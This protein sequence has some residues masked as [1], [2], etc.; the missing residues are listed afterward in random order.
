ML[1]RDS[2]L[3]IL[4]FVLAFA[5]RILSLDAFMMA[6]EQLWIRRSVDFLK[7]VLSFDFRDTLIS[8]HPG[9]VTMWLGSVPIAFAKKILHYGHLKDLLW[10]AKI[11]FAIATAATITAACALLLRTYGRRAALIAGLL[12]ATDPFFTA[13]SRIIHLDAVL[14]CTMTLSILFVIYFLRKAEEIKYLITS[15]VFGG[16]ALLAKVPGVFLIVFIPAVFFLDL[17]CRGRGEGGFAGCL[18]KRVK[19]YGI[20]LAT[21]AI[22]VFIFWPAMWVDPLTY[23]EL[24]TTGPGMVAHEHGQFY[25]GKPTDVPGFFYYPLILLF[26]TTPVTLIFAGVYVLVI[27]WNIAKNP[28]SYRTIDFGALVLIVFVFSFTIFISIPAKKME[29]YILPV[30]LSIDIIA[31]QGIYHFWQIVEK[32]PTKRVGAAVLSSAFAIGFIFQLWPLYSSFPYYSTYYNPLAGGAR[33]AAKEI[34]IGN[35]E[36]LDLVAAYLNKK[37][38]AAELTVASEFAYLLE[39][40]FKGKVKSTKVE[41]Y[42]PGTLDNSDYLV[43][44]ISGL[45][46][47]N[48]R[49]P[50]EVLQYYS[51]HKPEHVIELGGLVYASIFN[52]KNP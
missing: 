38:N 5:P 29:R 47:K 41:V 50:D 15:G 4:I 2:T 23:V 28:N 1:R 52:L 18:R 35:G 9:V 6:D 20:W 44:Y 14:S 31:A 8:G 25:M 49:L 40:F 30:F 17:I 37:K 19:D 34:L 51:K 27:L 10:P 26:R 16:L 12:L 21:A 32:W 11:P 33:T 24:L 22:V 7:A 13:Y 46:K 39:V 48:L 36:G 42:K 43:V 3:L 45:Q